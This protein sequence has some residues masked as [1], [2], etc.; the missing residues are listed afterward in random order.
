M[1]YLRTPRRAAHDGLLA[2]ALLAPFMA[3]GCGS[4]S[5]G[6][7]GQPVNDSSTTAAPPAPTTR[8]VYPAS[9]VVPDVPPG[10]WVR[11]DVYV[12]TAAVASFV[13][14]LT[15]VDSTP[16]LRDARI[17]WPATATVGIPTG[18]R[19]IVHP[20]AATLDVYRDGVTPTQAVGITLYGSRTIHVALPTRARPALIP[21]LAHELGHAHLAALGFPHAVADANDH[22]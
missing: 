3:W 21:V 1:N 7:P 20:P 2:L 5:S 16:A 17:A 19:L 12:C 14:G 22:P 6:A 8:H 11:P 13:G 18:W 4:S 15:E 10:S 9:F